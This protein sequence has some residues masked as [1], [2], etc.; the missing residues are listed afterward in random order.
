M[1]EENVGQEQPILDPSYQPAEADTR[2]L[3]SFLGNTAIVREMRMITGSLDPFQI[4]ALSKW[5]EMQGNIKL[6]EMQARELQKQRQSGIAVPGR[7]VPPD[8][9]P[10]S[11]R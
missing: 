4:L 6:A 9:D 11:L 3:I 2:I 1:T 7:Q 10:N 8:F 5:L